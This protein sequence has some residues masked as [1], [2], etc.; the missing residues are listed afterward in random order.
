MRIRAHRLPL[1]L[2]LGAIAISACDCPDDVSVIAPQIAVDVCAD[3]KRELAGKVLGGVR[4]CTLDFETSPITVR[5]TK[6]IRITN[7]SPVDLTIYEEKTGFTRDSGLEFEVEQMPGSVKAGQTA[8]GLISYRPLVES[9][10]EGTLVI[11]SDAANL[12]ESEDVIIHVKGTGVDDGVPDIVVSPLACEYGS[13]AITGVAQCTL[14]IENR[15]R[16]DLVFDEVALLEDQLVVPEDH[17]SEEAPFSF[18]GRPPAPNDILP[19]PP[20]DDTPPENLF[21]LTVRF[22]PQALGEYEGKL[23]I[24]TN[25]PDSPELVIPLSGK[26]VTPPTCNISVKSVNGVPGNT[27]IEPLDDVIL[28]AE[29]SLPAVDGGSIASVRWHVVS[30]PP[31]STAVLTNPTGVD[32]GFTFADGVLGVDLAGRYHVRAVVTDDLGTESVNQCELEFEA[33]P[34]DSFLV[35]LSWDVPVGDMDLHVMKMHNGQFCTTSSATD[36]SGLARGCGTDYSC[37]FG[38][39]KP[40][41]SS[42]PDW[43]GDGVRGSP[44]DPSLDIDDLCGYGP[45]QINIDE[46]PP[47]AYLVGVHFWGFTGCSGSGSTGNTIRIYI[48]GALAAEFFADMNRDDWWEPAIIYWPE[49]GQGAPCIEDLSTPEEECPGYAP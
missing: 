31:G 21:D 17:E 48:Y 8:I 14:T 30:Q 13:V 42:R 9:D 28:T 2:T 38:N 32:T 12:A 1:C 37:Y 39:C 44:G 18:V 36:S 40:T 46:A 26:G 3:P 29:G 41:S 35:Q 16:R 7:P 33:I 15:G 24:R 43:D 11:V 10:H 19:P 20:T 47:G 22:V 45:E 34:T 5:T 27:T 49:P 4:D 23:R 25:D 6:E